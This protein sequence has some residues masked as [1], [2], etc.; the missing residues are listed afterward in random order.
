[1]NIGGQVERQD[2]P[3]LKQDVWKFF[4]WLGDTTELDVY[5][6]FKPVSDIRP[7]QTTV[8]LDKV[9]NI[10][11]QIKRNPAITEDWVFVTDKH[12]AL[13]DGHH[14]MVALAKIDI[15]TLVK[16]IRVGT[17]MPV[18]IDLVREFVSTKSS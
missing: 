4:K 5:A 14:R 7:T 1:M 2:L 13:L 8:D 10:I 11:K 17:I 6:H 3:Q 18:L 16:V 15:N 9:D 12:Y